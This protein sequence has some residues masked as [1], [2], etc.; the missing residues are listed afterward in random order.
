M[1]GHRLCRLDEIDDPGARGFEVGQGP[2]PLALFVVRRGVEV[3]GYANRCPHAGHQLN[4]IGDR[5]LNRDRSHIQCASHGAVFEIHTGACVGGPCPGEA[6][7]RVGIT[8]RDG[9]VFA[10]KE[11]VRALMPEVRGASPA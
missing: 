4:W 9:T 7:Q 2:W 11:S 6:L 3:F 5:F 10:D 1:S 8:I